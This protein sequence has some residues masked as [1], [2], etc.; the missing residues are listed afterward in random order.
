MGFL[1]NSDSTIFRDYF[2]EAAK[3]LG[4]Q[5]KY[6]YPIDMTFSQYGDEDPRGF[7]EAKEID[8]IFEENPNI[9][10]LKKYGWVTENSDEVPYMAQF[11]Y[12][13]PNLAKG[14][15]I[16]I[17]SPIGMEKKINGRL[18][19]VTDIH[20]SLEFP[21]AWMCK[22]AP[23]FADKPVPQEVEQKVSS[24]NTNFLKVEL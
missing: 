14:C 11:A 12:D 22:L 13:T 16:E 9:R 20:T 24:E 21:E 23:V 6:S 8:I 10:T 5:V 7:S 15:R 2:K 1:I 19:V 17:P 3:L 18:F 4:I